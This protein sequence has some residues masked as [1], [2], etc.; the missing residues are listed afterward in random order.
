[1]NSP[2]IKNND[3]KKQ[4]KMT[5]IRKNNYKKIKGNAEECP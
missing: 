5:K 2:D 3:T 4:L 1:V